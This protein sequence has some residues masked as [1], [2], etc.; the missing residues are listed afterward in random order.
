[1]LPYMLLELPVSTQ[2][3]NNIS[4]IPNYDWKSSTKSQNVTCVNNLNVAPANMA[5]SPPPYRPLHPLANSSNRLYRPMGHRAAGGISEVC[6]LLEVS[7]QMCH[8]WITHWTVARRCPDYITRGA[9]SYKRP[10]CT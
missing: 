6:Y 8:A 2:L 5:N 4:F 7:W 3:S 1:M 10:N 9:V